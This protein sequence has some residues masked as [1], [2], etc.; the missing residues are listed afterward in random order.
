MAVMKE[1]TNENTQEIKSKTAIKL[2]EYTHFE[3]IVIIF[4]LI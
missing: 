4:K 3:C 1:N 2:N